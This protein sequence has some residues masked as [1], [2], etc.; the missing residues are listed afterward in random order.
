MNLI[1][2]I[3]LLIPGFLLAAISHA[4]TF[5]YGY[6]NENAKT[7]AITAY[8]GGDTKEITIP[9]NH[10]YNGVTYRVKGMRD[11]VLNGIKS[12]TTVN[13]GPNLE[14]I[15][16]DAARV[17]IPTNFID[18]PNLKRFSVDAANPKFASSPGG[19]LT[20][21][22][23][24]EIYRVPS[25]VSASGGVLNLNENNFHIW[26]DAFR[27]VTTVTTL[28]LRKVSGIIGN[29]GLN[30]ALNLKKITVDDDNNIFGV[31]ASGMLVEYSFD[32]AY[33]ISL[34]PKSDA[35]DISIPTVLSHKG[36]KSYVCRI[37]TKAFANCTN[38][39]SVSLPST[40]TEIEAKAFAS[41][42]I[43]GLSI[44]AS[45]TT[46]G[47]G[48]LSNCPNL[49]K[50]IFNSKNPYIPTNFARGSRKLT[51]L[52]FKD[53]VPTELGQSAFK[54]CT[55]LASFPFTSIT[56]VSDSIFANTGFKKV[57]FD[58]NAYNGGW[59]IS[60]GLFTGCRELTTLDMS[61]DY[62]ERIRKGY[63][64]NCPNLSTI[65][66]PQ[67]VDIEGQAFGI[68]NTLS[69]IV[70]G[71]FTLPDGAVFGY[72]EDA[73]PSVYIVTRKTWPDLTVPMGK[74]FKPSSG[75]KITPRVYTDAWTLTDTG[76]RPDYYGDN[77]SPIKN[78]I[79]HIPALASHNY[80]RYTK[81]SKVTEMFT[82]SVTRSGSK[83]R[84]EYR[85]A[86]SGVKFTSVNLG[87]GKSIALNP[88]GAV[89]TVD[90]PF[91]DVRSVTLAYT[92]NG[93][94]MLTR[95]PK[96]A[97]GDG[98]TSIDGMTRDDISPLCLE[99]RIARFDTEVA[100]TV[101]DMH[102]RTVTSGYGDM[103]D[104]S[105]LQAGIYIVRLP[106]ATHKILLR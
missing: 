105:N 52:T 6:Y 32:K 82:L 97:F 71:N 58:K 49:T 20:S 36:Q 12:L 75:A 86:I 17:Y 73:S 43:T 59:S 10:K 61:S 68:N 35:T 46:L 23:K 14:Y 51:T 44:P 9:D 91:K 101:T 27:G 53:G 8:D 40:V 4:D 47:D 67:T 57:T 18:C 95:Y 104:L 5:K 84:L 34:P 79:I 89:K 94:E 102:G 103:A 31:T 100:Y 41:S 21:E 65:L 80:R 7:C 13:I 48:I 55:S 33:I 106:I 88:D 64:T 77:S 85:P 87:D 99:G 29:G 16:S 72:S 28:N 78:A 30:E 39:R 38:L 93:V 37:D 66:F 96:S 22:D 24:Y 19:I 25:K 45:A 81:S 70:L 3:T 54:N 56:W 74:L 15:G 11:N 83:T 98:Q 76:G 90:I 62:S 63:A 92:V 69:K 1:K 50:I 42:G 2:K 60:S 26:D